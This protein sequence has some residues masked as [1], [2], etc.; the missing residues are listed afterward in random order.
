MLTRVIGGDSYNKK[1]S[2]CGAYVTA[3][4]IAQMLG[5]FSA[6]LKVTSFASQVCKAAVF[7]CSSFVFI[8]S[9]ALTCLVSNEQV[10]DNYRAISERPTMV[11][12]LHINRDGEQTS[13]ETSRMQCVM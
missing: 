11:R 1:V 13:K 4:R 5:K 10:L 2:T 7:Y 3:W 12:Y 9:L 8:R 6:S